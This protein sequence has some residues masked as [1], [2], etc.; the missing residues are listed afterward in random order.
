MKKTLICLVCLLG[1]NLSVFS[2]GNQE[3][4][5]EKLIDNLEEKTD[6]SQEKK[7]GLIAVFTEFSSSMKAAGRGDRSKMQSL[8][9]E[10]NQKVEKLLNEQEYKVYQ[11]MMQKFAKNGQRPSRKDGN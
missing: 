11:E 1:I 10:R 4:R 5:V 3:Q 2:Q 9:K 8:T 7:D 6:L